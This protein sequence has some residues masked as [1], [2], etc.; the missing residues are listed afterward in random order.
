MPYVAPVLCFALTSSVPQRRSHYA[1]ID[2]GTPVHIFHTSSPFLCSLTENHSQIVGFDGS[3]T[4]AVAKG[5]LTCR[6]RTNT[7]TLVPFKNANSALHVPDSLHCLFS[8]K[9]ATQSGCSITINSANAYITL[10][11]GF[12]IPLEFDNEINLWILPLFAPANT[13]N[14]IYPALKTTADEYA[15]TAMNSTPTDI[16]PITSITSAA[17]PPR[18][19]DLIQ[20]DR[21]AALNLHHRLG[22]LIRA[23]SENSRSMVSHRPKILVTSTARSAWPPKRDDILALPLLTLTPVLLLPG[24]TFTAISLAK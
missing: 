15:Q 11:D 13:H 18:D 23:F 10:P 14:D 16:D 22:H 8:V 24:L 6:L 2:S 9:M 19:V 3:T 5:D 4:R 1:I 12:D 17:A 7:G 20:D 21:A